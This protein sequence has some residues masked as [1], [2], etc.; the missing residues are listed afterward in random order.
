[1]HFYGRR[2]LAHRDAPSETDARL[3]TSGQRAGDPSLIVSRSSFVPWCASSRWRWLMTRG[4]AAPEVEKRLRG[5]WSPIRGTS[6]RSHTTHLPDGAVGVRCALLACR[7]GPFRFQRRFDRRGLECAG[8]LESH[9]CQFQTIPSD[10][11]QKTPRLNLLLVVQ[12][13]VAGR[14]HAHEHAGEAACGG[15]RHQREQKGC[16]QVAGYQRMHPRQ[17]A[18]REGADDRSERRPDDD[19]DHELAP[20]VTATIPPRGGRADLVPAEPR[21]LQLADGGKLLL[22]GSK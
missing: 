3:R 7:S 22:P 1:M 13:G 6:L 8:L 2:R 4:D 17:H 12:S 20:V 11:D 21:E 19:P 14:G 16:N 15:A 5:V 18:C 9:T 10:P